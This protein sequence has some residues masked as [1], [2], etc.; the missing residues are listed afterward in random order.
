M[1]TAQSL[2]YGRNVMMTAQSLIYGTPARA[3]WLFLCAII[4]WISL[5]AIAGTMPAAASSICGLHGAALHEHCWQCYAL[6]V[7]AIGFTLGAVR[8]LGTLY[9]PSSLH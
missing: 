6:A 8:E 5:A 3:A 9:H 2:I 7:A 4:A 1:M